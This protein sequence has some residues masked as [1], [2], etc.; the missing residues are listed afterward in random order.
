M[1]PRNTSGGI[2]NRNSMPVASNNRWTLPERA[3]IQGADI[4]DADARLEA[5]RQRWSLPNPSVPVALNI[6]DRQ[7]Y[8]KACCPHGL[9]PARPADEAADEPPEPVV[10]G[11]IRAS[12]GELRASLSSEPGNR[13]S[14][15]SKGPGM[16]EDLLP[17]CDDTPLERQW[18]F[19]FDEKP[20]HGARLTKGM[21]MH[22]RV[23]VMN[24]SDCRLP[25]KTHPSV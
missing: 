6:L 11:D 9:S 16:V 5:T 23:V 7:Y 25:P 24:E 18:T 19:W 22:P 15:A 13:S 3:M 17:D 20:R 21:S 1:I 14:V 2:V 8:T 10:P 4:G 12:M